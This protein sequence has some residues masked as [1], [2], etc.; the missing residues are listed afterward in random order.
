MSC[1]NKW[2]HDSVEAKV[3][4]Q[5]RP[6]SAEAWPHFRQ[7]QSLSSAPCSVCIEAAG[8]PQRAMGGRTCL[9][10]RTTM[11]RQG[12]R[13]LGEICQDQRVQ[14]STRNSRDQPAPDPGH[15]V[16]LATGPQPHREPTS[17][18]WQSN[19][20]EPRAHGLSLPALSVRGPSTW[21]GR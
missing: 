21:R 19:L 15:P 11:G 1:E 13:A 2:A 16:P 4:Q 3:D 12:R 18:S 7:L 9:N 10:S 8:R 17:R 14:E 20:R 6:G 5:K